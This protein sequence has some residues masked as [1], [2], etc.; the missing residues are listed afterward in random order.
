[1]DQSVYLFNVHMIFICV[2]YSEGNKYLQSEVN[3]FSWVK[4]E[5]FNKVV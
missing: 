4:R 3:T 5:V 1:M 2:V